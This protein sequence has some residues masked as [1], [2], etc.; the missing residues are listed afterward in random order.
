MGLSPTV[1]RRDDYYQFIM[2]DYTLMKFVGHP[3]S[4]NNC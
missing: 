2:T 4:F 1:F 3:V